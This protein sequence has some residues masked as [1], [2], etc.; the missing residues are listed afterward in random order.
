MELTS[1]EVR[2]KEAALESLEIELKEALQQQQDA[3][4]L[5][6]FSEN[7]ELEA[8][9][10]RVIELQRR[11]NMLLDQLA[12]Y[13]IIRPDRG[14]RISIGNYV[15][16]NKVDENNNPID[17]PRTMR[18]ASEGDTVNKKTLNVESPLG[19]AILNGTSAIYTVQT[20]GGAI[21]YNVKKENKG[22]G[23]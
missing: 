12:D 16:F 1:Q 5:M 19:K 7:S 9:T 15:T 10:S 6:D 4:A 18:L 17:E 14:P 13:S 20:A 8:A 11:K 2:E 22:F 23:A 3:K 21:R